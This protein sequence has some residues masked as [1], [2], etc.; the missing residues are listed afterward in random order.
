[1]TELPPQTITETEGVVKWFDPRKG[2]GFIIGPDGQDIFVHFSAIDGDGFRALKD[3]SSVVYDAQIS[4]K[5][6]KATRVRRSDPV[7][8][9]M[10]KRNYARTPRR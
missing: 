6:W 8:T 2:F 7:V 3:G 4:D 9:V 5:G 10:P 1:M